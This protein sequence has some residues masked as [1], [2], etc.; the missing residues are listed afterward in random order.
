MKS[1]QIILSCLIVLGLVVSARSQISPRLKDIKIFNADGMVIDTTAG[2]QIAVQLKFDR[3]MNPGINP[4]VRFGL[5]QPFETSL[6]VIDGWVAGDTLWQGTVNINQD[7]PP[8]P[9]GQ[10]I[11]EVTA[12]EDIFGVRMAPT[13]SSDL[14]KSLY[15]CRSGRLVLSTSIVDF[16]AT[17]LG[18]TKT[19]SFTVSNES[20]AELDLI[21]M[22]VSPP[23][24]FFNT[25][26]SFT[27]AGGAT[28]QISILFNPKSRN[29]FVKT[30][31]IQ[32][33]DVAQPEQ[34]LT[35]R[36]SA[37]GPQISISPDTSLDFG[38]LELGGSSLKGVVVS[39][40]PA[41]NPGNSLDLIVNNILPSSPDFQVVPTRFTLAPGDTKLV[42][43]VFEPTERREFNELLAFGS[44]D[45]LRQVVRIGMLG[46]SSD[47][48][49]PG[50]LD[51]LA[52]TWTGFDGFTNKDNLSICWDNPPDVSGI[53]EIWWKFSQTATPPT[54]PDDTTTAGGRAAIP[55][56]RQCAGLP[57]AGKL[58]GGFWNCY[59]WLVD[60]VGNS[61]YQNAVTTNFVYD[62]DA[63]PAP[64]VT[65]R[66]IGPAEWFSVGRTFKVTLAI[67][68]DPARG[69]RDAID[70]RWKYTLP[71]TSPVDFQERIELANGITSYDLIVPFASA[72]LQGQGNIYV[73]MA[74]STGNVSTQN[75]TVVPYRFDSV[76]P[77]V[78]RLRGRSPV[79]G[80]L[81][82]TFNDT[83]VITDLSGIESAAV[84]YRLSGSG[85]EASPLIVTRISNTNRFLVT[86]PA[87][88]VTRRGFEYRIRVMD[89]AQNETLG[90]EEAMACEV[91]GMA[92]IPVR[93]RVEGQGD[94]SL[95]SEGRA[96]P[97]LAGEDST[98][99][100]LF[101]IPYDL[102]NSSP[103][104][105]LTDDL[106]PYDKKKW[107]F[108]DYKGDNPPGQRYLEG[109]EA[110]PFVPGR[111][112]F[113]ITREENIVV[114]SGPGITVQTVCNDTLRL[115]E[116]WNLIASPFNFAVRQDAMLLIN[117]ASPISLRAYDR[118][119]NIVNKMEPWKGYALF[120]TRD[121]QN[122][123]PIALVVKPA[124]APVQVAKKV[125]ALLSQSTNEWSIQI[126]AGVENLHDNDNWAGI[127]EGAEAGFDIYE[128]AEPPV[129][130]SFIKVSFPHADWN[131]AAAEFSTDFRAAAVSDNVWDFAIETNVPS[132]A[133][134][135][136]FD[137]LGNIPDDANIF[138]VDELL[139][140]SQNLREQSVYSFT[141]GAAGATTKKLRLVVGSPEFT[142]R[143]AGDIGLLPTSFEL[144]QNFPNPFNPE[145][146][147]RYNLPEAG[148]VKLE[149]FD[150][151]GRHVVTLV[152]RDNHAAGFHQISWKGQD[153]SGRQVATGVYIYR[154]SS[155]KFTQ[156][157][158]ALLLK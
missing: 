23:Y 76:A 99:Y 119:W 88:N 53:G 32:S 70:L 111:S 80:H 18:T 5:Q 50:P 135:V 100:Q 73:W 63:P 30:L 150:L 34:T 69:V 136:D 55:A 125:N 75:V 1:L 122:N 51:N 140:L 157:R 101:S 13:L 147:I 106:G 58:T 126:S 149:V 35:V 3:Q 79:F 14:G 48:A 64:S 72:T 123:A 113:V 8:A 36:G 6:S 138:L 148:R 156:I 158:K 87:V 84:I 115:Q 57:L 22:T 154:L 2:G 121:S 38:R 20:C 49:P 93:T 91:G 97:L 81:A 39:N 59:L 11:F 17:L 29:D 144:F 95:D 21:N 153:D 134:R 83:L 78:K 41:S 19:L 90:P 43:V 117:S 145:T 107:R 94:V 151:L 112:F 4:Q 71:P 142:S 9:D 105:V 15:I 110:R 118:G 114:D 86:I 77:K 66:S 124:A 25:P 31:V 68:S 103:M 37:N 33:S 132:S 12:A 127:K 143:Q 45:L 89:F 46:D 152:D 52:I 60:S 26:T 67:P 98:R 56:G 65:A 7:I 128:L 109:D 28:R 40:L 54:S 47:D 120:V 16:G 130:G 62:I 96:A 141:S 10:Y 116:G 137:F 131:P 92:W 102:D 146:T 104:A 74:D 108:F 129:I 139:R 85:R 27:L 42:R 155:R 82:N 133:V 44:N 24:F 61:G